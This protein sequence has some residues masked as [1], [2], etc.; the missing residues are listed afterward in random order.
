MNDDNDEM[1][2][3]IDGLGIIIGWMRAKRASMKNIK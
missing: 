1:E 2:N 3:S